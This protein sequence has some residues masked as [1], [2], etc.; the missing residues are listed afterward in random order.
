[1]LGFDVQDTNAQVVY[2]G[3][4]ATAAFAFSLIITYE[5]VYH[6]VEIGLNP[7]Q[8]VTAGVVLECMTF[9][10]EIP[11]GV[12]ADAYSRRLSVIIGYFLI[13][14]GFLVEGLF[15]TFDSVLAAQVLWGIGFTFYSGAGDAWIADEIGEGKAAQIYLRGMQVSQVMSLV[16]VAVGAFLVSYGLNWPIVIGASIYLVMVPVLMWY[17]TESGYQ[18]SASKTVQHIFK[19][20]IRPFQESIGLIKVR[21]ILVTI[22][23]VGSVIG[24]SLGGFDR[25][26]AAHLT[27]NF[28]FPQ[29]GAFEP[30]A[31]FSIISG[32]IAVFSI[33]STEIVRKR[34]DV[35]SNSL[36]ARLLFSLY[37]GMI[38]CTLIFSWTGMFY[39]AVACFCISQ[40]LRNTGRPLLI[41]WINQNTSPQ[42]R[43][44]VISMYWQANA[45][46]N[47]V[48]TPIIGWIGTRFSIRIALASGAIIY[49]L[50][51]PFLRFSGKYPQTQSKNI[52]AS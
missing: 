27:E 1:M 8:L 30:V 6:T 7:L 43:A 39:A 45:L 36:V 5:L 34:L 47:I 48:G 41:I 13:G 40:T 52:H 46:G 42:V 16:G 50:V 18:P 9:F 3:M 12:V 33:V 11:T 15:A 51:L 17:M 20:I 22:L 32:I 44:T 24:L 29:L 35:T 21:P 19:N 4:R 28:L 14:S 26:Y 37:S 25:L 23:L 49:T 31:W 2:L 10:F 38:L